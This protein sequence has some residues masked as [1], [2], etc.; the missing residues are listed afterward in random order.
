MDKPNKSFL[1]YISL[2]ALSINVIVLVLGVLSIFFGCTTS[3]ISSEQPNCWL[4]V[5]IL[6][7]ILVF[8]YNIAVNLIFISA[9]LFF[10]PFA[11]YL[12]VNI[13]FIMVLLRHHTIDEVLT[14]FVLLPFALWCIVYFAFP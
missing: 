5:P 3:G 1:Y 12:I 4:Y 10:A 6:T 11:L 9:F 14:T 7:D 8:S 2:S 13:I